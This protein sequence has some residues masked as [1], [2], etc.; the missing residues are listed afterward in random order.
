MPGP[1]ISGQIRPR[2]NVRAE[3]VHNQDFFKKWVEES[4]AGDIEVADHVILSSMEQVQTFMDAGWPPAPALIACLYT[5]CVIAAQSNMDTHKFQQMLN[6][7][8]NLAF[9]CAKFMVMHAQNE[10][11]EILKREHDG[12]IVDIFGK[13]L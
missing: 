8:F 9:D 13:R 5:A 7:Q 11:A 3:V 4:F 10:M 6:H 12:A 1:Q 2:F